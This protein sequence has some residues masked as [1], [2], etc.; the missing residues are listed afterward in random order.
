MMQC[1]YTHK[2]AQW[3]V[4]GCVGVYLVIMYTTHT[5]R[6]TDTQTHTHTRHTLIHRQT[7]DC[8]HVC[9]R[10]CEMHFCAQECACMHFNVC[11]CV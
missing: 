8:V 11:M 6:H 4:E 2:A 3:S 9:V 10:E 7:H 1:A 5:H